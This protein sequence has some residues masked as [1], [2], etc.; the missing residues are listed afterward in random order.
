MRL[1]WLVTMLAATPAAADCVNGM[2]LETGVLARFDD[3]RVLRLGL[4]E[5]GAVFT[6]DGLD[7]P[8]GPYR[9]VLRH[10]FWPLESYGLR[11]DGRPDPLD[12]LEWLY[13]DRVPLPALE[14][15]MVWSGW[16]TPV[17]AGQ[18]RRS[19]NILV[20]VK[21]P[22]SLEVEGCS[23]N[24][25]AVLTLVDRAT[26]GPE[27]LW[28]LYLPDLGV[29]LPWRWAEEGGPV[30]EVTLLGLSVEGE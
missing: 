2:D 8:A 14:E 1:G 30:E 16:R 21:W 4:T 19:D 9:T 22:R 15:G 12:A 28:S 25:L 29:A 6:E 17:M 26:E 10:G 27:I 3:G 18:V 11:S 7:S 13:D 5:E 24:A 23:Y 20:S